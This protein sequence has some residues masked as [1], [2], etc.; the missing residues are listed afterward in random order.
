VDV[1]E[2]RDADGGVLRDL[3]SP[4]SGGWEMERD[5]LTYTRGQVHRTMVPQP[6]GGSVCIRE[7]RE[8]DTLGA[9]WIV[10][11]DDQDECWV[12][13]QELIEAFQRAGGSTDAGLAVVHLFWQP[14]GVASGMSFAQQGSADWTFSYTWANLTLGAGAG[15][16]ILLLAATWAV[17]PY[18]WPEP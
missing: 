5:S 8:N 7:W 15:Q 17:L 9:R 16:A 2:Q 11:G 14:E 4:A 10:L 6:G 12:R 13:A 1:F 3:A 18:V